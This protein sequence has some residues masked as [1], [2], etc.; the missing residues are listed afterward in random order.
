MNY[1]EAVREDAETIVA[2]QVAMAG[3]TEEIEL[4]PETC[5]KGVEAVFDD[6]SL[7]RYFVAEQDGRVVASLLITYEWSDWR[8]GM[9]WWIQSVYV[10]SQL[11]RKGVYR[12]LYD[13]VRQIARSDETIRGIRL[14]VDRRNTHAQKVYENLGMDGAHYIVFEWMKDF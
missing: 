2:F 13:H 3:E 7:G 10:E 4:D 1:R 9:V 12:G 6:P 5:R 14:Y 8:S 11:R